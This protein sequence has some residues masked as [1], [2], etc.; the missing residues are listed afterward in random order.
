MRVF[1]HLYRRVLRWAGHPHAPWYL[2][3]LSF[4][5]ASFF[6]IPPD[7][8]LLPMA[9][10]K[11]ER[12]LS[13]ASLATAASVAGGLLGY[14]IGHFGLELVTPWLHT[15]GYWN[16]YTEVAHW[17]ELYGFWV[18]LLAGFSPIPYKVFTIAAGALSLSLIPFLLASAAGR[19]G[20]FFLVTLLVSWG[21]PKVEPYLER[22][23]DRIG[24]AT[25]V[26]AA[27]V[28]VAWRMVR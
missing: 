3:A 20:R 10:A 28:L 12:G 6:P 2:A 1:S 24:W 8:M 11:P 23:I 5:E 4:A 17:F 7:V 21:G 14:A 27:V 26:F 22:Y 9:L 25:V 16:A 15:F 13:F 19:G 18:V